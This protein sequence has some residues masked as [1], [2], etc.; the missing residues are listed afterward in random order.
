M[1]IHKKLLVITALLLVFSLTSVA[2]PSPW[3]LG[4][5]N[6]A[7]QKNLIVEEADQN[8]LDYITRELFCRLVVRMVEV[9]NGSPIEVSIE[10]PFEDT[11]NES[12]VKAYQLG[13]VKGVS[14][15][16]FAPD[17]LITRQEV[18][19]MMMRA[20]RALDEIK[21][22]SFSKDIDVSGIHF[23]DEDK[24]AEWALLE[25]K[26]ANK[27]NIVKGVGSNKINPLGNTTV[28]QSIL[29]NLRIYLLFNPP[30][31]GGGGGGGTPEPQN[32]PPYADDALHEFELT[33][34]GKLPIDADDVFKDP[35]N[36]IIRIVS[37]NLVKDE[38]GISPK[39]LG[40]MKIDKNGNL[41]YLAGALAGSEQYEIVASDGM[42]L[43]KPVT[44]TMTIVKDEISP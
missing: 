1:K 17:S 4:E 25:I 6:E 44:I 23:A 39:P 21:G 8:Y 28:E 36:D 26:E 37:A 33:I 10:N 11:I 19:V 31:G 13:I 20:L 41:L 42:A 2:A 35:E 15:T 43:S 32:Q 40:E 9:V 16:K 27:L 34:N 14:A 5:V 24:I 22:T 29:L 7:R 18:A 30:S 12:I 38:T 3:A